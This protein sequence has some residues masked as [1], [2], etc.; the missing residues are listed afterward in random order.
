MEANGAVKRTTP[1]VRERLGQLPLFLEAY[2]IYLALLIVLIAAAIVAPAF[3]SPGNLFNVLRQSSI[4][5]VVA[6]GQTLVILG[7][8]IDLSVGAVMGLAMIVATEVT[9]GKDDP[10]LAA[11]LLALAMGAGVGMLNGLLVTKR[12]VPP[13]VATLGML[14]L[15][16]GARLAYTRGI[17]SG[18]IPT[19]LRFFGRDS[20]GP[21][22]AAFVTV[23]V[24]AI[25]VSIVLNRTTY[26]RALFAT[27]G[28]RQ[29]AK[30]SGVR[31][32]AIIISTYVIC[33]MLAIVG[34]LLLSGYIGYVDRYL[35]RGFDLDSIAAVIV[36]G[37][38][39]SG[40][41]GGIGGTLAGVLL[42]TALLNI[43][44]ILNLNLQLQLVVKGLVIVGAVA[45]YSFRA[46][47]F[48]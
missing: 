43:V 7:G 31:V 26:G 14:V 22:P 37:T 32:D 45:L 19:A 13:F 28:N 38:S 33:S 48:V 24:V 21:F 44:L 41:R 18:S 16:E 8:G 12:N 9:G 20:I 25:V 1:G 5:G 42:V 3:Y 15:I 35:G 27:G 40:G 36:G 6:I 34:G 11:V 4:L 47:S 10:V 46:R 29:A 23:V 39:F 17:P 30:L 2:G